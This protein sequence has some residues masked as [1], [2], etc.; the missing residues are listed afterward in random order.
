[1]NTEL[2]DELKSLLD[3]EDFDAIRIRARDVI[4]AY[5]DEKDKGTAAA[6]DEDEHGSEE[7]EVM[8]AE[9]DDTL[10]QEM[11]ALIRRYNDRWREWRKACEEEE[12]RN[13]VVRR[14]LIAEIHDLVQH[15]ENIGRAFSRMKA[16]EEKWKETG[17]VP[18][19]QFMDVQNEYS[20][21]RDQF[22]HNIRIYKEL[23][24]ND[25]KRNYSLK[26]Q[27]V[28]EMEQLAAVENI[29]EVEAK[30]RELRNRWD[31][32]G[33]THQDHWEQIRSRY[34]TGMKAVYDRIGAFYDQMRA[35]EQVIADKKKVL[36]GQLET[37]V[38]VEPQSHKEWDEATA[39]IKALQDE[40]RQTGAAS[41]KDERELWK[42]LRAICDGFFER[43][44]AFYNARNEVF[45][46]HRAKKEELIKKA[47][48]LRGSDNWGETSNALIQLQ[49]QWKTIGHAGP[50]HENRLWKKFRA[51][52]DEFFNARQSAAEEKDKALAGN[53]TARE[54]VIEKMNA[55]QPTEDRE[56]DLSAVKAFEDEFNACG[57]V[58][59]AEKGKM[60]SKFQ[61]A[62]D[63]MY[64][65][66]Q[67]DG[68][69]RAMMVFRSY[70]DN[71]KGDEP[72]I[73][74]EYRKLRKE[75]GDIE[76]EINQIETNL[77]FFGRSSKGNPMLDQFRQKIEAGRKRLE[78]VD[79]Q[80]KYLRKINA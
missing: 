76:A 5:R 60:A 45:N 78:V 34:Y 52:C 25:L 51:I 75:K 18:R 65:K 49:K 40:F 37:A 38:Q 12:K 13:L 43:K 57:D 59:A 1:M 19:D 27:V 17:A 8:S 42:Q 10:I 67:I 16:I 6:T 9:T 55:W 64:G 39:A 73:Q 14:D 26:N 33:P 20:R 68:L 46:E 32:I 29:R 23:Q 21:A 22:Y 79:Q 30:V 15:E 50:K 77:A 7:A 2:K 3:Q 80:M 63:S 48:S 31:E 66:L 58:P 69:E 71:L 61:K 62:L 4:R 54:A 74:D 11:E 36:L 72:A 56:A 44:S 35:A 28:H 24:E 53:L 70:A 47:E 41:R